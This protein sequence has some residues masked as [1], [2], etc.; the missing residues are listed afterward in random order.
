M[1][2]LYHVLNIPLSLCLFTLTVGTCQSLVGLEEDI[3]PC[4]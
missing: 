1:L 3:K 4:M 2:L